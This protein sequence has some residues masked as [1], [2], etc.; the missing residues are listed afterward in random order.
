MPALAPPETRNKTS[1]A[2]LMTAGVRVIR[3]M[4]PA[5]A[6]AAITQRVCS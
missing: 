6:C 4:D 1:A 5:A 3:H 2:A